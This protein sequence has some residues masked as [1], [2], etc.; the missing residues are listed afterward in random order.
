MSPV[1]E[2]KERIEG[3]YSYPFS[4]NFELTGLV[5]LWLKDDRAKTCDEKMYERKHDLSQQH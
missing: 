4:N 1:T 2:V 3:N 5:A